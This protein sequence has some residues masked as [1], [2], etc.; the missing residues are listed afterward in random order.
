MKKKFYQVEMASTTYR[1]WE[2]QAES[3]K[4]AQEIAFAEMDADWEISSEWKRGADI[5]SC[6]PF[7][8]D[9][10][11]VKIIG[12]SHMSNEEFGKYLRENT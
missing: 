1:T 4:K 2:V 6:E 10:H 12:T 7:Y 11:G 9:E 3:A 8:I 5:E